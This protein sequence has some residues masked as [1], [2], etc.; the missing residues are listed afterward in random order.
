MPLRLV[1]LI[2][3]KIK[4]SFVGLIYEKSLLESKKKM[5][6]CV[7]VCVCVYVGGGGGGNNYCCLIMFE[8]CVVTSNFLSGF[9]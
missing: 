1:K 3:M 8:V 9:K 6:E 2:F 7:C 5:G 4:Y